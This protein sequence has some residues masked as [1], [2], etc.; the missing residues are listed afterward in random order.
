MRRLELLSGFEPEAEVVGRVELD[1]QLAQ[2][3]ERV[4]SEAIRA[5]SGCPVCI[6]FVA[7]PREDEPGYELRN[8]AVT[9]SGSP[10]A[11]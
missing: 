8:A 10:G 7:S 6:A 2:T 11:R 1:E 5:R 3:V 4:L 9:F